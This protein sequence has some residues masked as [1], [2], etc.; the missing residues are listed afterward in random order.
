V[1]WIRVY[2]KEPEVWL[3]NQR[4]QKEKAAHVRVPVAALFREGVIG[5]TISRCWWLMS[6]F[7]VYYSIFGLFATDMTKELHLSAARVGWP[8]VFSD[9]L[10]FIFSFVWGALTDS[11]GRRWEMIIPA[12]I[13]AC[14]AP[15]YPLTTDYMTIPVAFSIQGAFAGA[16]HGI[17]PSYTSERFPTEIRATAAAWLSPDALGGQRRSGG[18][19]SPV[20]PAGANFRVAA[21]QRA[22]T[23]VHYP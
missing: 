17:N 16:I 11:I 9:G 4:Q 22:R 15:I 5:H 12:C 3:E 23:L 18:V 13:G 1:V 20:S 6:A 21:L 8:L 19:I 14:V 10:T 2:V 7:T